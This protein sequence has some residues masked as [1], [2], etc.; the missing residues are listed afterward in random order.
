M[1]ENLSSKM[2]EFEIYKT[3]KYQLRRDNLND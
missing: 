2:H 3:V 1:T